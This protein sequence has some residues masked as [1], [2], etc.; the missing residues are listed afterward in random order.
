MLGPMK[1]LLKVLAFL[2]GTAVFLL[3]AAHFTLRYKLNTPKFKA[4]LTGFI[5]RGTGRAADYE[6]VDYSLFPFSLVVRNAV[7]REKGGAQEFASIREFSA[8]LDFRAREITSLRLDR[9]AL[10]IVQRADGT[11]NFSDLISKPSGNEPAPGP[12]PKKPSGQGRP[13]P[14]GEEPAAA[15][16]FTIRQV[17]IEDARFEFVRQRTDQTE[18]SFT[19]SDLDFHLQDFAPD[20]P[21]QVNGQVAIGGKSSFRF[22]LSGPPPAEYAGNPGAWPVAF[23]ARLDLADFADV[24]AFLPEGTLPFQSLDATVET[25]G[26]LTDRL[27]VQMKFQTPAESTEDFPVA[28]DAGLQATLSLPAPVADHLLNGS[29]LPES[30]RVPAPPCQPPPGAV[31]L[32]D[33]PELAL[34]LRHLQATAELTFPKI[35]YGRNVFTQG[36]ATAYLRGGV[37]TVPLVKVSAYGGT[38]EARGN[39]QLLACPLSYRLD[40]LVA[41]DLAIEQALAANGLGDFA[42]LSGRIQLEG[43]AAGQA[44]AAPGLRSLEADVR[45]RIDGLQSIGPGGSLMDQVWVQLD[46]PLLLQLVPRL[47]SKVEQAKHNAENVTTSHYDEATATLSLREGRAALS[48]ARLSM[49]GYRLLAA[50]DLF[51]FDDRLDLS[52]RLLASPAETAQL[53]GG[54]DCSAYLPYEDGGLMVPLTL[55]DSLRKPDVR[56]DLDRL[57][58]NALAGGAGGKPGNPLEHLSDSDRKHVEKG[59]EILGGLLQP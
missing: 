42:D 12:A 15:P 19:L 24:K 25:Q 20:R 3:A 17:R 10:R 59:L 48:D 51:P 21:V 32:T 49:P 5:E 36:L 45:A 31:A 16:P 18:E 13:A 11:F 39:A 54:K 33:H 37:L 58:Q 56:P 34:L 47:E 1:K 44:V 43:S 23:T 9:P 53:T 38:L 27:S 46:N 6:R 50:G 30:M 52:A 8:A 29:P 57:L 35:A 55:R 7:I 26:A 41:K 2:A 40:R 4:A 14:K 22:D 28:L